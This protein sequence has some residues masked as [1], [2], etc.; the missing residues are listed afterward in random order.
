MDVPTAVHIYNWHQVPFDNDYPHYFPVKNG[1]RDSV[2]KLQEAGV[3]VMPY[4]NARLWDSDT[5]DFKTVALPAAAKKENG[6][7]Y[8]EIYGSKEK[9]VPMCPTTMLW[10]N[11]IENIVM[12]LVSP[13]IGVDGV[14]LDQVSA[15]SPAL[16]YDPSHGHPLG[17]GHWWT[18][19]GYWPMLEHLQNTLSVKYP[20]KMLTSE[21]NAE[22]YIHVF[23][24]YL[25]WH[26]QFNN[27][28]PLFSAVYG[29]TIQ[30]FGRAYS[31][32]D[33]A[34]HRMRI[35]QSLV[36]GEQLGWINP[37]I[38]EDKETAQFLREAARVRYA[39][40]PFLSWGEMMRP[41]HI[42]GNIPLITAEW[43]W[44]PEEKQVTDSAVQ[45]GA[46]RSQDGRTAF[47]FA[48]VSED[49]VAFTWSFDS[50]DYGLGK[51][52]LL[53]E[54]WNGRGEPHSLKQKQDIP[55]HLSGREVQ[56]YIVSESP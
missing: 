33:R 32:N 28:V 47:I 43:G 14:Y 6:E 26:F 34:A 44:A 51:K 39:L 7:Y 2:K 49:T 42:S 52:N 38:I 31:G 18:A 25:T 19:D 45:R 41:P 11:T 23:D 22:P 56:A 24:G 8:I 30:Q 1:F 36:F 15:M 16:C 20:D 48:N 10:H 21:C 54:S 55:M 50:S 4:I 3:R 12:Q 46:W 29:G 17:G 37:N 5:E 27:M 53:I 9:L 40:L 13:E 35:G